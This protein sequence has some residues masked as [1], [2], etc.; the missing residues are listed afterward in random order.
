[1]KS[2]R[3]NLELEARSNF[4]RAGAARAKGVWQT[5]LG[6]ELRKLEWIFFKHSL[7]LE[8][9]PKKPL[10]PGRGLTWC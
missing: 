2:A 9:I 1:M 7:S 8:E 3:K 5:K 10:V 4:F 6:V